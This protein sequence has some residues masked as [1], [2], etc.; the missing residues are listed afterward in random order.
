MSARRR[1]PLFASAALCVALSSCGTLYSRGTHAVFGAYPFQGVAV[2]A[3]MITGTFRNDHEV[4][5]AQGIMSLPLDLVIDL[6]LCP[7]DL[8]AWA[9]GGRKGFV[10]V[11]ES[12]PA[13]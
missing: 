5:I 10:P 1:I 12:E 8:I 11:D 13:R 7:L 6:A 9:L 3:V 2:D 4:Y